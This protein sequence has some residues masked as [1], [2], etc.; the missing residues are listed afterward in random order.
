MKARPR[1]RTGAK[2]QNKRRN[3]KGFLRGLATAQ[4]VPVVINSHPW[5]VT[6][7]LDKTGKIVYLGVSLVGVEITLFFQ[8]NQP[9][10]ESHGFLKGGDHPGKEILLR[11]RWELYGFPKLPGLFGPACPAANSRHGST[12]WPSRLHPGHPARN[13]R[14][15]CCWLTPGLW[16]RRR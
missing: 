13:H 16:A 10:L 2:P 12:P 14:L 15:R 11:R 5:Q 8:R 9:D 6:F 4:P 3:L 1:G 7:V